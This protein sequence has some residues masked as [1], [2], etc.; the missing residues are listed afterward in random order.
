MRIAI[1]GLSKDNSNV[2]TNHAYT[3]VALES[4]RSIELGERMSKSSRSID[5]T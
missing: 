2:R 1:I 5:F 4:F 3:H